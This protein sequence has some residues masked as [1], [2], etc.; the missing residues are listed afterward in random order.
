MEYVDRIAAGAVAPDFTL[1]DNRNRPV[2]LADLRGRKVLLS[3]HPLAWT[4]VCA[5]QMKSLEAH[6]DDFERLKTVA[7][8]LSVDSVPCKNQWA[9]QLLIVRTALLSDFWPHGGVAASYGLFRK[10]D[11]Y[12]ERANVLLDEEGKVVWVKVYPIPELPDIREVLTVLE[13]QEVL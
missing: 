6:T 2:H 10:Q 11:G 13:H 4:K 1:K 3:W 5:E 7:L 9:K 8:G 12:S